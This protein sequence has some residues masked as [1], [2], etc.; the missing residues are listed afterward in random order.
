MI[1]RYGETIEKPITNYYGMRKAVRELYNDPSLTSNLC[2]RLLELRDKSKN[3]E[4]L[5]IS[6]S[7]Y[8]VEVDFKNKD[9]KFKDTSKILKRISEFISDNSSK[10]EN[11]ISDNDSFTM[12]LNP[13][14][15]LF[16]DMW[17]V[18]NSL[19]INL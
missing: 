19:K 3:I 8:I 18:G 14:Y 17:T 16:C 6:T 10:I 5:N 13:S 2:S 11:S 9:E 12:F 1:E 15:C 4:S 7:E